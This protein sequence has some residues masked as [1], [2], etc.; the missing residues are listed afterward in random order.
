M[1]KNTNIEQD[2]NTRL[3]KVHKRVHPEP[4]WMR[5]VLHVFRYLM[6]KP[7]NVV[8]SHIASCILVLLYDKLT[9]DYKRGRL[10]AIDLTSQRTSND[11]GTGTK[12][13]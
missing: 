8:Y 7:K 13:S 10:Y 4:L 6:R 12:K 9:Y 1:D 3:F 5:L 11:T 2:F